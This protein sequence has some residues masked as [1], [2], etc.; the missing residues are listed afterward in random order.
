ME[1]P[2]S[3]WVNHVEFFWIKTLSLDLIIITACF[4]QLGSL[5][6]SEEK[7]VEEGKGEKP[8]NGCLSLHFCVF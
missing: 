7:A 6:H 1:A 4:L 8:L 3:S 5:W 2:C